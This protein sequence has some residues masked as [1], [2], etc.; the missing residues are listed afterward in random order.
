MVK[1]C[2]STVEFFLLM[3]ILC[4]CGASELKERDTKN[5]S[6]KK[7]QNEE[8]TGETN[9]LNDY[10]PYKNNQT[11]SFAGRLLDYSVEGNI[12]LQ[13]HKEMEG[14]KGELW[15]ITM[16]EIDDSERSKE[17]LKTVLSIYDSLHYF[18]VTEDKIYW[19]EKEKLSNIKKKKI[20]NQAQLPKDADV[21]C[22]KKEKVV[23]RDGWHYT[24][25]IDEKNFISYSACFKLEQEAS[26]LRNITF[27]KG[28]GIVKFSSQATLAGAE[29]IEL[30][31]ERFYHSEEYTVI[32]RN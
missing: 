17:E 30:W 8:Y 32:N 7:I 10:F 4:G 3:L 12:I 11:V 22:Q 27:K 24:I 16:A 13:F 20:C 28:V 2:C 19:I 18:F 25:N 14:K 1:R 6:V 29:S 21:V 15:Q 26:Y 31:D 23:N 9:H 5:H